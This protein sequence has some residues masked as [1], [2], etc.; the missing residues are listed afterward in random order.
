M[1]ASLAAL[2]LS[3]LTAAEPASAAAITPVADT[4]ALMPKH[5]TVSIAPAKQ[6]EDSLATGNGVMGARSQ[7]GLDAIRWDMEAGTL[8]TTMTSGVSQDIALVLPPGMAVDNLTFN[9]IS[10]AV[11]PQGAGKQGCKL[12]LSKGKPVL[13][14]AKFHPETQ[15]PNILHI[16]ADDHR[17]DGLH[18]LGNKVLKTP[19]L[20][21]LVARGITFTRCYTMGSMVGAVCQPSR[22]MLLT[23]LS[24]R[25][26]PKPNAGDHARTLPAVLSVE[27]LFP[28]FC[29]FA[30]AQAPPGVE[31]RSLRPIIEA[32][33]AKVRDALY[34]GYRDCQ[35]A[36]RDDRWKLIRYPLVDRT[37]FFDLAADPHELKDLA[38]KPKY[39]ATISE[40]TGLLQK[41]MQRYDDAAPLTVANPRP[42][43]WSPP[44]QEPMP[45]G[46]NRP[47]SKQ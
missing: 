18:A 41:E 26:I 47:N 1:T 30:G 3:G 9:G 2:A 20:D 46:E 33:Q 27:H 37:Q 23:G 32:R 14:E 7:I 21:T 38:G 40:L 31:G 11:S 5:G 4:A 22:T 36:I 17:P 6:W 16:H 34:T 8:S 43:A 45:G 10:Q 13:I 15:K 39:A 35:R 19:N 29:D 12:T 25:R 28:T 42:A 44:A 24:W